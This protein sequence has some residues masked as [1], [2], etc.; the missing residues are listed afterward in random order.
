MYDM[1]S[2]GGLA[3]ASGGCV[4]AE[5]HSN[6]LTGLGTPHRADSVPQ[7][8]DPD[9]DSA[10]ASGQLQMYNA[11]R[12]MTIMKSNLQSAAIYRALAINGAPNIRPLALC[13]ELITSWAELGD[14]LGQLVTIGLCA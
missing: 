12:A 4:K 13:A 10:A 5:A 14:K 11:D 8:P 6:G 1:I 2:E 3:M 7:A 9:V